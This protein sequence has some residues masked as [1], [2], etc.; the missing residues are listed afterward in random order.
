M[1][2]REV[3]SFDKIVTDADFE[4]FLEKPYLLS[5]YIKYRLSD[6]I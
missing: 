6:P 5:E 2:K 4:K 3:N 1:A